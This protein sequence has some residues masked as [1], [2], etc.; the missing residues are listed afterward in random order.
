MLVAGL[1]ELDI[2]HIQYLKHAFFLDVS[3]EEATVAFK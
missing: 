1:E 3:E 2:K